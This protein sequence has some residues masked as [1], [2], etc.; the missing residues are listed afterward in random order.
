MG[1]RNGMQIKARFDE[2]VYVISVGW[3]DLLMF[4]L[5]GKDLRVF[6]QQLGSEMGNLLKTLYEKVGGRTYFVNNVGPLG[7]IPNNRELSGLEKCNKELNVA[8]VEYNRVLDEVLL[9]FSRISDD[10]TVVVVA[11]SHK[12]FWISF[13]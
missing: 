10:S 1:R 11:N 13:S 8:A 7:C 5:K 3:N 12:L 2:A 6:A 9:N 4:S